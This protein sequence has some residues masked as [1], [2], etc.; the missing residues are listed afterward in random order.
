M[1]LYGKTN[2]RRK[3]SM[4]NSNELDYQGISIMFKLVSLATI[5]Y[6]L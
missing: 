1:Y 6:L 4:A 5:N 2:P 3:E